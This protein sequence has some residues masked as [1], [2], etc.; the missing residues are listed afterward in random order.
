VVTDDNATKLPP[1][2]RQAPD[3]GT[4]S[5]VRRIAD[6]AQRAFGQ[7]FVEHLVSKGLSRADSE[8]AVA[9]VMPDWAR[10]QIDATLAQADDQSFSR[11]AVLDVIDARGLFASPDGLDMGAAIVRAQPC[12]FSVQERLGIFP[13][14]FGF[15]GA[16]Q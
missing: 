14:E 12:R 11:A 16:G 5:V 8:R 2:P 4:D 9:E 3:D 15:G 13:G 6:K 10:C 7:P 1:S